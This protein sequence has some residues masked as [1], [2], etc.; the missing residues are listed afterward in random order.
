MSVVI[1]ASEQNLTG[2]QVFSLP[3]GLALH[4][5]L[6]SLIKVLNITRSDENK[7]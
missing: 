7:H 2:L 3:E 4:L 6:S 1:F 5:A